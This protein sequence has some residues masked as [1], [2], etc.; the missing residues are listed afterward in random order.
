MARVSSFPH[1]HLLSQVP[2]NAL[3]EV[4]VTLPLLRALPRFAEKPSPKSVASLSRIPDQSIDA[5]RT[6]VV[7][8]TVSLYGFDLNTPDPA[9]RQMG[10]ALKQSITTFLT[11]WYGLHVVPSNQNANFVIANDVPPSMASSLAPKLVHQK[12]NPIVLVL[13]SHSSRFDRST[14]TGTA[15]KS[16]GYVAKPVGPLKLARALTQCLDGIP[17]VVTPSISETHR[18]AEG[19]GLNRSFEELSPTLN[20]AEILDNSRM[21]ADS[22]N[23]RKAIESP[24]PGPADT[25]IEFPF[26]VKAPVSKVEATIPERRAPGLESPPT[27]E[28][29]EMGITPKPAISPTLNVAAP[30]KDTAKAPC[31]PRLLLVD[32][33]IINLALL[34]T[35]MRKRAYDTVDEAENGLVAVNRFAERA[36]GYDII[37]MDISMPI[38]DGFGASRQIRAVE[39]SRR[40]AAAAEQAD[41]LAKS[42]QGKL[43]RGE[44]LGNDISDEEAQ[45][46]KTKKK[47]SEPALI[48][49]LTGL[50][51][52]QDQ[53]EALSSGIDLFLTKPV[54]FREVGKLLDNWEANR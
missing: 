4:K 45:K 10:H 53:S 6:R 21:S 23:A 46:K 30:M 18:P 2:T 5:L 44:K 29:L 8:Q 3:A 32:D 54:A 25:C 37:F 36:D 15:A 14:P 12:K 26:P 19:A 1:N 20:R 17:P 11:D 7:G 31:K 27:E 50:A 34:R 40:N 49:A 28:L 48:I 13:C 51:S 39:A 9:A 47:I 38:L 52:T 24:T 22:T 41:A 35:Y 42:H 16:I 33:N 43:T